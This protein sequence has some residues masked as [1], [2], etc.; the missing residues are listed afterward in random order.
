[1][2]RNIH[3]S[4]LVLSAAVLLT[5]HP[6]IADDNPATSS[7]MSGLVVPYDGFLSMDGVAENGTRE[8]SFELYQM[9]TDGVPVWAEAQTVQFYNGR[10]SVG[11]GHVTPITETLLDAEKLY[12]A[13]SV[14]DDTG[15]AIRLGG[16]QVIER[17][18]YAVWSAQR[19]L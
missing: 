1:M 5:P 15:V 4:T 12:L 2:T 18:P 11:L 13:V 10:F 6:L 3:F 9:P 19:R 16:R 14:T 7:V 8:L 17:A